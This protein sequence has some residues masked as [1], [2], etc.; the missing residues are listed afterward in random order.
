V[1]AAAA[2]HSGHVEILLP[3]RAGRNPKTA[4]N[5][6]LAAG[7]VGA[8]AIEL[9]FIPDIRESRQLDAG[10]WPACSSERI[11]RYNRESAVTVMLSD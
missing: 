7:T 9:V 3:A 5:A 6:R 4:K 10:W 11:H 2:C 1:A 8:D